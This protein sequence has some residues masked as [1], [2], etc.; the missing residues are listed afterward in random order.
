M[1][2]LV[3][4]I[5]SEITPNNLDAHIRLL[6]KKI[7]TKTYQPIVNV[8]GI[9]YIRWRYNVFQK[10]QWKLT[11]AYT[12]ILVLVLIFANVFIYVLLENSN[13]KRLSE[14]MSPNA[15]YHRRLRMVG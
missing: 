11:L 3:W 10:L 13:N 15:I 12:F 6:R 5:D 2:D 14:E 9:G 8:R 4:V 7:E 1:I